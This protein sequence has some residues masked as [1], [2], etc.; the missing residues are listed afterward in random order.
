LCADCTLCAHCTL[1]ADCTW[2]VP[3]TVCKAGQF[4]SNGDEMCKLNYISAGPVNSILSATNETQRAA[5]QKYAEVQPIYNSTRLISFSLKLKAVC[6]S[7]RPT[8]RLSVKLSFR[9]DATYG[10]PCC[11]KQ[12][13]RTHRHTHT[14]S[15]RGPNEAPRHMPCTTTDV[16]RLLSNHPVTFRRVRTIVKS[17][18]WLSHVRPSVRTEQQG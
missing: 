10:R 17:Y 12:K 8:D 2:Q 4:Y 18:C 11:D 16:F 5:T 15:V 13:K 9:T 3:C 6:P 14:H 1:C 7:V